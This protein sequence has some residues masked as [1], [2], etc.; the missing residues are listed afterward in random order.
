M[1]NGYNPAEAE[2]DKKLISLEIV[3]FIEDDFENEHF[4]GFNREA[5]VFTYS[6]SMCQ[7]GR[8]AASGQSG[9]WWL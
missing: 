4:S 1:P 9:W 7:A 6:E 8:V 5:E 2:F 3:A